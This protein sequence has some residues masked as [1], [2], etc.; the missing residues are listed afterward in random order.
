MML[1]C[2]DEIPFLHG[3]ATAKAF[4]E[5]ARRADRGEVLGAAVAIWTSGRDSEIGVVGVFE[6]SPHLA[7]YAVSKLQDALLYPK[8]RTGR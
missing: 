7:H 2:A 8:R 5:L 6:C 4:R 1:R 3:A